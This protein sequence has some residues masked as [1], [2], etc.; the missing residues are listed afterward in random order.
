MK[1]TSLKIPDVKIIEP[2]LFKDERGY[3]FEAFN[4]KNFNQLFN[5]DL[6]FVQDNQ[7]KSLRGVLR[8]LH[9]QHEPYSQGKLVRVISGEV[10]DVAVDL[11]TDS[12]TYGKWVG[13]YLS[14]VN[15]KQLWIPS[16][17]A[18][19]FLTI[20]DKAEFL[21]KTTNFYNK[22]SEITIRYDDLDLDIKWPKINDKFLSDKD[23]KG[24]SF[25][26]FNLT[27]RG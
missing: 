9:F 24:I 23:K 11:R 13:E 3:F 5:L 2:E 12:L 4:Q 25:K 19:G 1:V 15:K 10:F 17:F 27:R 6:T 20:S 26:N 22:N 21:Y 8:G 14:D 18:H 16:G 7:S